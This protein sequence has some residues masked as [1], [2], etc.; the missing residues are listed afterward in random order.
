[1]IRKTHA[2]D[3]VRHH[4]LDFIRITVDTVQSEGGPEGAE[5]HL[6]V[7]VTCKPSCLSASDP[8]LSRRFL[9]QM[10]A[11]SGARLYLRLLEQRPQ[12]TLSS[13]LHGG[14]HAHADQP[15]LRPLQALIV[16][17]HIAFLDGFDEG[18]IGL[19]QPRE[20]REQGARRETGFEQAEG[21]E[22]GQYQSRMSACPLRPARLRHDRNAR[23][24]NATHSTFRCE[25]AGQ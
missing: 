21:D 13:T 1:M 2:E 12:T 24:D 25:D 4:A 9:V 19:F 23:R 15:R 5:R 17:A 7:F 11:M 3:H 8:R 10:T 16:L 18:S 22:V 6:A 14:V 20:E